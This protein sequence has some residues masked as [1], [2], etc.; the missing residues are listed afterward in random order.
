MKI[1]AFE[2]SCDESAVALLDCERRVAVEKIYSQVAIH[3]VFGGVVPELAAREHLAAF[4]RLLRLLAAEEDL[5]QVNRMA[6]TIGPGLAGCLAMGLAAAESVNLLYPVPLQGVNHLRAHALSPFFAPWQRGFSPLEYLPHL[7]LLVSGGNTLLF[8]L[9][10]NFSFQILAETV[11]DAAGEAF[12]KGAKLLQLP[13]PGGALIEK[14]ARQGE[15]TAFRFPRAFQGGEMKFSFSGLKTS[16]RYLLEKMSPEEISQQRSHICASY[17]D[18]IC[19]VLVEKLFL[20]LSCH[21]VR[22]VGLSGGVSQNCY[23]RQAVES[24]LKSRLPL[25]LAPRELCGDNATMVA[26][27]ALF[28]NRL[29]DFPQEFFPR[30]PIDQ[31]PLASF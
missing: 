28:D 16:L 31:S 6:V 8:L 15:K 2:S 25:L 7:G 12:D 18:A 3:Q 5:S 10:E 22:S 13:Y 26:F 23:L 27:A 4:P 24:Q 9:E 14:L 30:W 11:D 21:K 19:D 1:L 17:Q 20:A 29:L